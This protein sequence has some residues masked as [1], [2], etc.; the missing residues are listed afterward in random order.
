MDSIMDQNETK[1]ST[2]R[3]IVK[4]ANDAVVFGAIAFSA[5]TL[6]RLAY[7]GCKAGVKAL[8]D[9]KNSKTEEN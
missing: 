8:K 9:K 1:T 3:N 7:D 6:G 5:Y 4:T 2:S